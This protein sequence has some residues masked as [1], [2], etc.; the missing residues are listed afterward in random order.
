MRIP[1]ARFT[2]RRRMVAVAVTG[3]A[4]GA[5]LLQ[6]GHASGEGCDHDQCH[7]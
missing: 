7:L 3:F 5:L 4:V 1:R 2:V 6:A